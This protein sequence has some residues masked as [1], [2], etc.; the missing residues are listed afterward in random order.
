[1]GLKQCPRCR[2]MKNIRK[3]KVMCKRCEDEFT[4]ERKKA[5]D[6]QKTQ[7]I[8]LVCACGKC[9]EKKGCG[10]PLGD[11][12]FQFYCGEKCDWCDDGHIHYC[13]DCRDKIKNKKNKNLSD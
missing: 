12:E 3:N 6:V 4:L 7:G 13:E 9:H 10:K 2:C 8:K 1:M 5:S 11:D